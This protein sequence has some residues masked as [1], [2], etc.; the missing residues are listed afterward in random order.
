[1]CTIIAIANF[2]GGVAKTTSTINIGASM[3][4]QGKRVLLI[5]LDPQYNLTQSLGIYEE[6]KYHIYGALKE[7]YPLK[8][9][10]ISENLDIIASSLDLIKAEVELSHKFKREEI[11]NRLLEPLKA[12]YDYI[13]MDCPPSLGVL[14]IN[15]FVASDHIYV[16]IESEFLALKGYTVLSEAISWVGLEIDKVFITKYDQRKVLNRNVVESVGEALGDKMF[17]SII[18]QNVTLAEAP[19][20]GLDVFRYNDKS[21]GAKDYAAL[22]TEILSTLEN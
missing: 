16:P 22:T 11:L 19:A 1:M 3:S 20:E 4:R 6:Q 18:R 12:S 17:K 10:C 9:I 14:T 2:K 5:D 21:N 15:A 7:E 13:L 8:P